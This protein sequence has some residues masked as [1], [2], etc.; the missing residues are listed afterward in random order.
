[1]GEWDRGEGYGD[2]IR[3]DIPISRRN[4]EFLQHN[5]LHYIRQLLDLFRR[6]D[7]LDHVDFTRG[8]VKR[9]LDITIE[10][11][12]IFSVNLPLG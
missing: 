4:I 11:R 9:V 8:I 7:M 1:M 6:A 12:E 10:E 3:R 2:E 5:L